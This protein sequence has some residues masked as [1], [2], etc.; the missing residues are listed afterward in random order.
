MLNI[1][2]CW[3]TAAPNPT[4]KALL[5]VLPCGGERLAFGF[6]SR[7][8]YFVVGHEWPTYAGYWFCIGCCIM[9]A[10]AFSSLFRSFRRESSGIVGAHVGFW[11]SDN[12]AC[13]RHTAYR[14]AVMQI[15]CVPQSPT[16]QAVGF[17]RFWSLAVGQAPPYTFLLWVPPCGGER[18][19]FW[20][21]FARRVFCCRP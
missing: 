11:T 7:G 3:V 16:S 21:C 14:V 13:L 12:G 17:V 4:Y 15:F 2:R 19:A 18:L 8:G 1:S 20:L 10:I 9:D 6:V 5:W